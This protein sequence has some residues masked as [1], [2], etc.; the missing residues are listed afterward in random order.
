VYREYRWFALVLL[1][2]VISFAIR[3]SAGGRPAESRADIAALPD[4]A[5]H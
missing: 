5:H 1:A 3:L 4:E 2:M